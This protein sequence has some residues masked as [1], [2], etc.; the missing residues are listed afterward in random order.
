MYYGP[1][2]RR[3]T[4]RGGPMSRASLG[5]LLLISIRLPES[6]HEGIREAWARGCCHPRDTELP[7]LLTK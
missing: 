7:V 4:A 1:Q 3:Q 2:P 5:G 6:L